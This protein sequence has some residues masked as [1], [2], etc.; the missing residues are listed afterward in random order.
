[1]ARKITRKI[2]N[3]H[4]IKQHL[5]ILKRMHRRTG[6]FVA[7]PKRKT[8]Y[9]KAWLRDNFYECLAFFVLKDYA[10]CKKT[11]KALLKIFEK[12]EYKIDHAIAKKP[13]HK[14]QYIHARY[15]PHTFDEFWED[16]GN[17]Q[18]DA[19]GAIL[20]GIGKLEDAGVRVIESKKDEELIQKLVRYLGSIEYWHDQDS[21][22]W[23]EDEET[24]ASSVGACLA[25]LLAIRKYVNVPEH[26]IEEGWKSLNHLL[27]RES[28]KKYVD[29]AQLSLIYPYNVVSKEQRTLILSNIEYHLLKARGLIR[30]K[31]DAYYNKNPDGYSEEAEWAFGLSW[32]AIIYERLGDKKK[33]K[34][35]L[36][37]A[38][39]VDT[40][41]GM[42]ELYY[43]QTNEYNENTP[44]GWSESMF[45]IALHDF[46]EE[47]F[48]KK[49]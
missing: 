44:L 14:H 21:G 31:N 43:S 2:K 28:K 19:V 33:S 40:P 9:N 38:V 17:K 4:L 18:N 41:K 27:P 8:G 6:L 10:V 30:Y 48:K 7:S 35:F 34:Y 1:M 16:W 29:L 47:H 11:Y 32:L 39:S 49:K 45:I 37:K 3:K 5:K 46:N 20:W 26:M 12:H 23:E 13:E 36:E 25:G 24:H 42:P 15:H 22:M